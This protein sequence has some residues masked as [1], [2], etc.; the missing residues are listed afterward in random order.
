[1]ILSSDKEPD[2]LQKIEDDIRIVGNALAVALAV[3][4]IEMVSQTNA[5]GRLSIVEFQ[6]WYA[7]QTPG[8]E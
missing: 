1:M 6:K 8:G 7:E 5:K 3:M 2:R 4:P